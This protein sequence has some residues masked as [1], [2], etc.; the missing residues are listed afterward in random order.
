MSSL[1]FGTSVPFNNSTVSSSSL[2]AP[3][4]SASLSQ[5]RALD[6]QDPSDPD[7]TTKQYRYVDNNDKFP[8]GLKAMKNIPR[9][10]GDLPCRVGRGVVKPLTAADSIPREITYSPQCSDVNPVDNS[11]LTSELASVCIGD[12]LF[13]FDGVNAFADFSNTMPSTAEQAVF[14]GVASAPMELNPPNF[15]GG[16]RMP[17]ASRG[18]ITTYNSG[19]WNLSPNQRLMMLPNASG[20]LQDNQTLTSIEGMSECRLLGAWVPFGMNTKERSSQITWDPSKRNP[21]GLR[22]IEA[23]NYSCCNED[24]PSTIAIGFR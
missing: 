2:S 6:P 11:Q 5:K 14:V 13:T 17:V 4:F 24:D 18:I 15:A 7:A 23:V 1:N 21:H 20:I 22:S 9:G 12:P 19:C 10:L 3:A 16:K 8:V